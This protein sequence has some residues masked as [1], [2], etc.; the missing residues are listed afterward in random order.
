MAK[1]CT[2]SAGNP[3]KCRMQLNKK[4]QLNPTCMLTE[5]PLWNV[6]CTSESA[7]D[8]TWCSACLTVMSWFS[9]KPSST[10]QGPM[11]LPKHRL[12]SSAAYRTS[13]DQ[14]SHLQPSHLRPQPILVVKL[15][16]A[17][18][19]LPHARAAYE[20]S[21]YTGVFWPISDIRQARSLFDILWY[22]PR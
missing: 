22:V 20:A 11:C 2:N 4:H 3:H 18:A 14:P 8:A 17:L 6:R 10:A 1:S 21:K 19:M 5:P 12:S 7:A 13:S 16:H 9:L 15:K